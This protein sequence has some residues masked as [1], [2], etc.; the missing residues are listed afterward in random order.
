MTVRG[1]KRQRPEDFK[2][3][4][5]LEMFGERKLCSGDSLPGTVAIIPHF[6][7]K[8]NGVTALRYIWID[9]SL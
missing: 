1:L 5:L 7:K 8:E 2:M 9:K 3:K 6:Y 4:K